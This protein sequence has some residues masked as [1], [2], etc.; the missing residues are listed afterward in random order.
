MAIVTGTLL[1]LK[2]A[3]ALMAKKTAAV[4]AKGAAK[5]AMKAKAKDFVKGKVK[6]K[7]KSIA[8][9]KLLG[10]GGGSGG[11]GLVK[12]GS[13]GGALVKTETT[14]TV[15]QEANIAAAGR[16]GSNPLLNEVIWRTQTEEFWVNFKVWGMLPI[17]FIF[18]AF[19]IGLIN[20]YKLNE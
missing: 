19:Q 16:S 1:A 7:L 2:G 9:D 11:G 3:G 5:G 10:G 15:K 18:T 4:A 12:T 20:K 14:N 13:I 8:K 6:G 17:T